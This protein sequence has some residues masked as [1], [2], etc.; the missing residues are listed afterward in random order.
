M[1]RNSCSCSWV[2]W[3]LPAWQLWGEAPCS[4][5]LWPRRSQQKY[6]WTGKERKIEGE[7]GRQAP[8]RLGMMCLVVLWHLHTRNTFYSLY[9]TDQ[10]ACSCCSRIYMFLQLLINSFNAKLLLKLHFN[11]LTTFAINFL[12]LLIFLQHST[13]PH[14]PLHPSFS[15]SNPLCTARWH[16]I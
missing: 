8:L 3:R 6:S 13:Q 5:A 14:S 1:C 15:H 2:S 11:S 12:S 10:V 16:S 4:H 7:S 9:A